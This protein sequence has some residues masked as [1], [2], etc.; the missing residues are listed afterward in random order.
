MA[1]LVGSQGWVR[2]VAP[3][4]DPGDGATVARRG[5]RPGCHMAGLA[6]LPPMVRLRLRAVRCIDTIGCWLVG[7]GCERTAIALWELCGL[8]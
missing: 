6:P 1:N 5:N 4:P 8:W 7:H 3:P 2:A